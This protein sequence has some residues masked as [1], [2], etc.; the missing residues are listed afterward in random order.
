MSRANWTITALLICIAVAL[1]FYYR[2]PATQISRA[3]PEIASSTTTSTAAEITPS[4]N[5]TPPIVTHKS[6]TKVSAPVRASVSS[7]AS[8]PVSAPMANRPLQFNS[9]ISSGSREALQQQANKLQDILV[10]NPTNYAAWIDLGTVRK[11]AG[12]YEGARQAWELV[13]KAMPNDPVGVLNLGNLY[14]FYIHDYKMSEMY[15]QKGLAMLPTDISSYHNLYDVLVGSKQPAKA[16]ALLMQG[17]QANPKA[18]DLQ[19]LLARFYIEQGRLEDAKI[20]YKKAIVNAQSQ[21]LNDLAASIQTD[22]EN[23]H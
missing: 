7:T 8:A 22:L 13:A 3:E 14:G 19:V 6:V 5:A 2:A 23:L 9:L 11:N 10:K 18:I 15:L 21:N 20:A 16:E 4:A 12:D 1:V 17:I